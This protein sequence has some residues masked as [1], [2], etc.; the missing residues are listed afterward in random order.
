MKKI[1]AYSIIF[2]L[3]A[4]PVFGASYYGCATASVNANSTFCATPSGSCAGSDPVTAA[5]ALAGTHS[6][7]ANGCTLSIT[8]SF[9]ATKIS[10]EDGDSAGPAVSGGG[11]TLALNTVSGKTITADITTGDT[12]VLTM[13]GN[14]AAAVPAVTL[15]GNLTGGSGSGDYAVTTNHTNGTVYIGTVE[16]PVTVTG[17]ANISAYGYT[18]SGSGATTG[19]CTM[20]AATSPAIYISSSSTNSFTGNATGSGNAHALRNVSTGTTTINGNCVGSPN[21][22]GAGCMAESTGPI[23]VVGSIVASDRAVGAAGTIRW[24]PATPA[25]GVT[26]HYV[27]LDGGGTP[28][29]VGPNT[30]DASKAL[31]T[32]YYIDPTD[33]TSDVGT[34]SAGGGGAWLF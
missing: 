1:I 2:I 3:M 30:D 26:G 24:T 9:T 12:V 7:Y 32:F 15:Q 13:T 5:T 18:S 11:F 28:V 29:F 20:N 21:G 19:W 31:S 4:H 8:D 23:V 17:G 25:L 6:L 10:T 22:Y 34:A 14:A 33:G 16:T 27:S